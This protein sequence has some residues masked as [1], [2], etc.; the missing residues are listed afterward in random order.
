MR[1]LG[2]PLK[3]TFHY[4]KKFN[5]LMQFPLKKACPMD[6]IAIQAYP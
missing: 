3:K 4:K 5:R 2:K 6:A 1:T